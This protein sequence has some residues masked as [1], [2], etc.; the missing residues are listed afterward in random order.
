MGPL[1]A[2]PTAIEIAGFRPRP[3]R[4]VSRLRT[5]R[6]LSEGLQG[7]RAKQ[8]SH[9]GTVKFWSVRVPPLT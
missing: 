9:T 6:P 4:Q 5:P 2:L 7:L 3:T 8:E 1:T